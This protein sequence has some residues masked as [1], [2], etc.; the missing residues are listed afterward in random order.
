MDTKKQKEVIPTIKIDSKLVAEIT[1]FKQM[2]EAGRKLL[3][4][5]DNHPMNPHKTKL[6]TVVEISQYMGQ[7]KRTIDSYREKDWKTFNNKYKKEIRADNIQSCNPKIIN[8][9]VKPNNRYKY[10]L[11]NHQKD[12]EN[13]YAEKEKEKT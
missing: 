9:K 8:T 7:Q 10:V 6:G 13:Y 4:D 12:M 5:N 11:D 2:E 1:K 3:D